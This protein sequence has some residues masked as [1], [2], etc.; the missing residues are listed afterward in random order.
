[1]SRRLQRTLRQGRFH[2]TIDQAFE[3]V[4][5][6]CA[7]RPEGTWISNG[8]RRGYR[9]LHEL[10]WVHSF[11][12]WTEDEQLAGGLYGLAVGGLFQ[13]ESMFHTV[14]D[15][16]KAAMVAM[17]QH[18]VERGFTLVDVQQLTPHVERM[19]G[20]EIPRDDYLSLLEQAL[21]QDRDV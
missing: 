8:Y 18:L 7:D 11:E 13:A 20:I 14:S 9:A 1:M 3:S 4:L 16:S 19:G 17:M 10:G 21:V 15:G 2:A 5:R 6:G 12:T